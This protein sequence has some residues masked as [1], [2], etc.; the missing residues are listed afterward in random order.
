MVKSLSFQSVF[1]R[2]AFASM[3]YYFLKC[4]L[5]MILKFEIIRTR[6]NSS[7]HQSNQNHNGK[8]SIDAQ[9]TPY[10]VLD[11]VCGKI[12]ANSKFYTFC[13]YPSMYSYKH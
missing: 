5:K 3:P 10:T 4:T 8:I 7:S 12:E 9:D 2:E 11:I 1:I 13:V 6:W